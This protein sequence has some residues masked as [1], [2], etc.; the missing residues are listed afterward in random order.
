MNTFLTVKLI[1]HV[2]RIPG[3]EIHL[4]RFDEQPL[5]MFAATF[6]GWSTQS[7]GRFPF[8]TGQSC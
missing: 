3:L 7:K 6:D 8:D 2:H 5:A 4:K 1:A